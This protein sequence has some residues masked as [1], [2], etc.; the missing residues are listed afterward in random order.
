MVFHLIIISFKGFQIK[1]LYH[2]SLLHLLRL[3]LLTVV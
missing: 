2:F 3:L 1:Q